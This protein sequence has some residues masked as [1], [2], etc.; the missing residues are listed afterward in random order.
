MSLSPFDRP[1]FD[2]LFYNDFPLFPVF[3]S[4]FRNN[5]L[6]TKLNMR[7]DLKETENEYI[8]SADIPG[9]ND[10]NKIDVSL[11]NNVLTISAEKSEEKSDTKTNYHITERTYG[12]YSRSISIPK[13]VN[14]EKLTAKYTDGVLLVTIL[15]D[16]SNPKSKTI[17]VD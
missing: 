1:N 16:N 2:S 11:N 9:I 15:K 4:T 8:V 12:S 10:K 14:S 3:P 5:E 17:R 13:N 6:S 7:V